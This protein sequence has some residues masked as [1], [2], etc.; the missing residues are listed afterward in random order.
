MNYQFKAVYVTNMMHI[1][2]LFFLWKPERV[3]P[4]IELQKGCIVPKEKQVYGEWVWQQTWR[5]EPKSQRSVPWILTV[6]RGLTSIT[7]SSRDFIH[8]LLA[9]VQLCWEQYRIAPSRS[10]QSNLNSALAVE[11]GMWPLKP[12]VI[13]VTTCSKHCKLC[14]FRNFQNVVTLLDFRKENSKS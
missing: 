4:H 9:T 3:L 1:L 11:K 7:N 6:P 14:W 12:N 8:V 2:Y 13:N 10:H 5:T